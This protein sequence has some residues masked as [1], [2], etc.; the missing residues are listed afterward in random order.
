MTRYERLFRY[1][2]STVAVIII[3]VAAKSQGE[4]P[5]QSCRDLHFVNKKYEEKKNERNRKSFYLFNA[6]KLMKKNSC[7]QLQPEKF[8]PTIQQ[9]II[10]LDMLRRIIKV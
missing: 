4:L 3:C 2:T 1:R 9:L 6:V 5:L 8:S 10:G 7:I